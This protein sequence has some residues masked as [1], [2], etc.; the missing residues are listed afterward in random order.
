MKQNRITVSDEQTIKDIQWLFALP[1]RCTNDFFYHWTIH[2]ENDW[3]VATDGNWIRMVKSVGSEDGDYS[4]LLQGSKVELVE[5]KSDRFW[6]FPASWKRFKQILPSLKVR[7]TFFRKQQM[8]YYLYKNDL[9]IDYKLLSSLPEAIYALVD[10]G[11][12]CII[13]S[14]DWDTRI[15]ILPC[16]EED[17]PESDKD[18]VGFKE[19][20]DANRER[21]DKAEDSE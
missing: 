7:E 1:V 9:V 21:C 13:I 12:G 6:N 5:K 19:A 10:T 8:I 16:I 4:L 3:L 17:L 18:W 11:V 20:E 2:V 15:T 14:E